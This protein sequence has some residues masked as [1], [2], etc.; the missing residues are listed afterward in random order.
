VHK[1]SKYFRRSHILLIADLILLELFLVAIYLIFRIFLPF[2]NESFNIL[3]SDSTSVV[4]GVLYFTTLSIIELILILNVV[5]RWA[6]EEYEVRDDTIVHKR[7]IFTTSEEKYS[8]RS[9]GNASITQSLFGKIFN[10]G[11]IRIYSPL[12]K[13]DYFISNVHDPRSILTSIEDDLSDK[14]SKETIIRRF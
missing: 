4:I 11:T 3:I 13:Q 12:L 6:S 2:F 10:Y 7:G 9:L 5:V 1:S 8:L 14:Q